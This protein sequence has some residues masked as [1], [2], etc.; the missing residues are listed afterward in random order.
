[1]VDV[2]AQGPES[3]DI[4]VSPPAHIQSMI[5]ELEEKLCQSVA[6]VPGAHVENNTFCLSCHY[7]NVEQDKW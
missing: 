2:T 7:R 3:V 1:M 5:S 6:A 4:A